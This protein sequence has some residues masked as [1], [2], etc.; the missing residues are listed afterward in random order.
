MLN[1]DDVLALH[2]LGWRVVP[3]PRAGKR[4]LE[5]WKAAQ[6][7]PATETEIRAG[8]E[9]KD[10]NVFLITGSI[11]KLCV[12]D[13]DD[14]RAIGYWRERLGPVLDET[15]CASTGNGKHYYFSLAEGEIH[16]GRSAGGGKSGKWDLRA[17][18]GGVIA[19]PSIHPSWRVYRWQSKRGPEGL[20]PA[21]AELWTQTGDSENNEPASRS[22]LSHLLSH[23]PAEG[24]RNNW[25]A[26]V[27]GHYALHI[28]P[29]DAFVELVQQA[30]S[31]AGLSGGEV[32]RLINSIWQIEQ[33]KKGKALPVVEGETRQEGGD[34]RITRPSEGSGWLVSGLT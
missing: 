19:P 3:A 20:K 10:R 24:N 28:P 2:D 5:S 29:F 1:F 17:E 22:L 33:A 16:R 7:T 6:E 25:L 21:P 9:G 34:W 14:Q 32:D 27:A 4:P 11:S 31:Q 18:G 12:L 30:A 8:F 15:T 26:Q 13:C 23:P